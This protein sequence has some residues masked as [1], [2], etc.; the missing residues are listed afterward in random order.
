MSKTIN[1]LHWLAPN[2]CRKFFCPKKFLCK[3]KTAENKNEQ[4][5]LPVL[6]DCCHACS[7]KIL[8]QNTGIDWIFMA[9][10]CIINS[11]QYRIILSADT[12]SEVRQLLSQKRR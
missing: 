10:A 12:A 7:A 6:S 9:M 2:L 11:G 4:K 8:H 3:Q 5:K 1:F